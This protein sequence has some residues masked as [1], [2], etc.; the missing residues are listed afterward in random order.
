MWFPAK[1]G[2]G[3][4]FS[5][6]KLISFLPLLGLFSWLSF[7]SIATMF[8]SFS[9]LVQNRCTSWT[10]NRRHSPLKTDANTHSNRV[11]ACGEL[12]DLRKTLRYRLESRK[13]RAR[14]FNKL[15]IR[16]M[17]ERENNLL[18]NDN[19]RN[20]KRRRNENNAI[21]I[22]N[23]V[24]WKFRIIIGV[25]LIIKRTN[26]SRVSLLIHFCLMEIFARHPWENNPTI[27]STSSWCVCFVAFPQKQKKSTINSERSEKRWKMDLPTTRDPNFNVTFDGQSSPSAFRQL[28]KPRW[29]L[30]NVQA[31]LEAIFSLFPIFRIIKLSRVFEIYHRAMWVL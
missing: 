13:F 10:Q 21:V 17:F 15:Q 5:L 28:K 29:V 14:E 18:S 22:K 30:I 2:L 20:D 8:L 6:C 19:P 12:K 27:E 26:L 11:A 25:K 31:I 24:P 23:T 16:G 7:Q 3:K 9:S 1:L 4:D